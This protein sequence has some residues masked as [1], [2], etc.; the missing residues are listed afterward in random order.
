MPAMSESFVDLSY[1]GL[2][3][4][5]RIKLTQVRPSTGYL[6]MPTPMPVG[7]AIGIATDDGVAIEAQVAAIHEQVGGSDRPPGMLV[8]PKLDADAQ[9]W[10]SARVALPELAPPANPEAAPAKV[11]VVSRR[12]TG[13][14]A[15]PELVDDGHNTSVMNAI[16]DT[17][18]AD[19]PVVISSRA[20]NPGMA[21]VTESPN[22]IIDD[23]KRTMMMDAVDLAALGLD[24]SISG[25]MPVMTE[26]EDEP[27]GVVE[28]SGDKVDGGKKKK[29]KKR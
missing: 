21:V 4:G 14:T 13:D 10:W 17:Q 18:V 1:R 11:T 3:L 6:E 22:Q 8:R 25:Q 29:K 19:V 5:K 23:G 20:T 15:V 12:R 2:A 16:D 7:T 24:P 26:V 9:T 28:A 27:S